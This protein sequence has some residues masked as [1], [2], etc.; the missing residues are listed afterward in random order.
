MKDWKSNWKRQINRLGQLSL[1]LYVRARIALYVR[2][3]VLV[4][5]RWRRCWRGSRS[6]RK[7]QTVKLHPWKKLRR[8]VLLVSINQLLTKIYKYKIV[9]LVTE[10]NIC[11]VLLTVRVNQQQI[12]V[13]RMIRRKSNSN[14]K[15][16]KQMAL[17]NLNFKTARLKLNLAR[18]L[19]MRILK[20]TQL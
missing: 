20:P 19:A 3:R 17:P 18:W 16:T 1:A 11:F 4:R 7:M 9:N 12:T 6:K 14:K 2:A 15:L 8:L 13:R 10:S 5:I